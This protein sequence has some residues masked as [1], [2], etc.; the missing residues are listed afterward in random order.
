MPAK[1]GR[2][3]PCPC[4]RGKK[5]KRCCL[6]LEQMA[7]R[8]SAQQET[9]FAEDENER[10]E[11]AYD[12]DDIEYETA[13]DDWLPLDVGAITRIRYTRGLVDTID[14]A[15]EGRGLLVTEWEA[16]NIPQV[17]LDGI[18]REELDAL[19]GEWGDSTLAD[20][21]QVEMIDLET[22]DETFSIE[23][24]NRG[25][26]LL[27]TDSDEMRRIHRV[28]E[29]LR[30]S[31]AAGHPATVIDVSSGEAQ[32]DTVAAID[33]SN[34]AKQHRQQ[35]G[36]CDL[37]GAIITRRK[38]RAH[39][40]TCAPAHDSLTGDGQALVHLQA[41][42]PGLPAYWLDLEVRIKERLE[43]LDAFLRR[44]WLECCGHLS[45]FRIGASEYYSRGYQLD[46]EPFAVFGRHR[47]APRSMSARL[48][49]VLPAVGERFRYEYDFGSTT[50]LDLKVIGERTGRPG[51][52]AVRLLARNTPPTWPCGVCGGPA[53]LLCSFCY[54]SGEHP[55]V[56][57]THGRRHTCGEREGFMPVVNS[58]RMGVCG[59]SG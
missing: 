33:W 25:I 37:C 21:I 47:P 45:L 26:S 44:V 10:D 5:F 51:R 31:E 19:E 13:D 18:E 15:Y 6:P 59:Y 28:C 54:A 56:C 16:P 38:S 57:R 12:T 29:T 55:F 8:E 36:A 35:P 50:C 20:P 1:P 24:F 30:S 42:A 4:G 48:G 17:V 40:A 43:A 14:D 2:N 52:A 34:I 58:P 7:A 9:L 3:D 27:S 11:P 46:S 22:G 32:Q 53:T 49:E 23:I 41:A 39:F